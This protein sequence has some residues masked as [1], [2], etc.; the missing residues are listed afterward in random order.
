MATQ[1]PDAR[2]YPR[3]SSLAHLQDV[4][5]RSLRRDAEPGEARAGDDVL[6]PGRAGLGAERQPDLLGQRGFCSIASPAAGS[7]II[8]VPSSARLSYTC[9]AAPIGSPMSCSASNVVTRS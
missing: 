9:R 5:E 7:T 2:W 6:D 3:W 8:Q 1:P 4:V